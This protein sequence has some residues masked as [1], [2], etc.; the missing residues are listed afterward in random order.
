MFLFDPALLPEIDSAVWIA[1]CCRTLPNLRVSQEERKSAT[2]SGLQIIRKQIDSPTQQP[3]PSD[4]LTLA[5]FD[6][7]CYM[8]EVDGLLWG[9]SKLSNDEPK[10]KAFREPGC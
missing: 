2:P 7:L 6:S 9:E 4:E 3:T 8:P 10:R 5:D 1:G